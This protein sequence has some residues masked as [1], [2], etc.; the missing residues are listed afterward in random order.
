MT[1]THT[2]AGL[3]VSAATYDE[4]AA[5]LRAAGYDHAFDGDVIDMNGI[6][7][8]RAET[9]TGENHERTDPRHHE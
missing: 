2:Y 7:L 9:T 6:G 4:I 1:C 5:K 8:I 3:E